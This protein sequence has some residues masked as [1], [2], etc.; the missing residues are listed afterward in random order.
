MKATDITDSTINK[1]HCDIIIDNIKELKILISDNSEEWLKKGKGFALTNIN[2][3]QNSLN[4]LKAYF[5]QL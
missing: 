1:A 2:E 3:V 5:N 4:E